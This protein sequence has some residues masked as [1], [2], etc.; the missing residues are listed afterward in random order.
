MSL[1]DLRKQLRELRKMHCPPVSRMKK[2]EVAMEVERLKGNK[3]T[4]VVVREK[5]KKEKEAVL[6]MVPEVPKPMKKMF[7]AMVMKESA[8]EPMSA[9]EPIK[10]PRKARV[11][12]EDKEEK[13]KTI[14]KGMV[15]ARVPTEK[16]A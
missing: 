10:A 6:P 16:K 7:K 12:M 9:P 2:T 14:K 1:S 15:K 8:P 5:A 11:P 13:P 3:A 4:E